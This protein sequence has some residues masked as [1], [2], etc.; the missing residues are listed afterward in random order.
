MS[1]RPRLP[2]LTA[3]AKPSFATVT[4][5]AGEVMDE[6]FTLYAHLWQP[7]IVADELRELTRIRNARITDC[8]Y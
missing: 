3:G 6:F 5:H 4:A 8:G 7:G 2:T 1:S